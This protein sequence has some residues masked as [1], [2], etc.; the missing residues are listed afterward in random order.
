MTSQSQQTTPAPDALLDKWRRKAWLWRLFLPS[1]F[2]A[3]VSPVAGERLV[4]HKTTNDYLVMN[5]QVETQTINAKQAA[6]YSTD[7]NYRPQEFKKEKLEIIANEQQSLCGDCAGNGSVPC[8]PT[9]PCDRCA[10]SGSFPCPPTQPCRK[11]AGK[12][13]IPCPPGQPC[14]KC[15]GPNPA[16]M[17]AMRRPGQSHA[18]THF[19]P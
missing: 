12:G 10:G 9:Q 3:Q 17:Y 11:C 15:K 7:L 13:S 16:K 2:M 4:C 8:P 19:L 6:R 5:D 1:D 14:R 18:A